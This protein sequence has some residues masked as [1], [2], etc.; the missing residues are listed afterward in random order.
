MLAGLI[1][2]VWIA[3][4]RRTEAF[5]VSRRQVVNAARAG[6]LILV[7][8]IGLVTVAEQDVPSALAALLIA[9][10]P[11]W[12]ILLRLIHREHVARRT[13]GSM[14]LGFAGL[15]FLL[16]P[17][18]R[19]QG[20]DWGSSLLVVAAA[21]STA[22]GAFYSTRWDMPKNAVVGTV[23]EMLAAGGTLLAAAAATREW[24]EVAAVEMSWPS[25]IAFMYLVT[26]GSVI[27]Y[28]AFVWLLD[29]APVSLVAT[30]AYVN[31]VIAMVLGV[32]LLDEHVSAVMAAGAFAIVA[33]VVAVVRT[34]G[35]A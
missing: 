20:A 9:S 26:F 18:G 6:L 5:D 22:L 3:A 31:P 8:G 10:I 12:V 13:I 19:T 2:G 7:G 32:L 1:L 33:S 28:T 34:E 30:Y 14:A 24:S 21:V 25:V 27:A 4:R 35:S 23:I 15:V 11:L 29:N 17:E 16:L